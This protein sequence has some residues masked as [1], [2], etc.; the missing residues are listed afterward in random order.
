MKVGI[1]VQDE[2]P[3]LGLV[4]PRRL[5]RSLTRPGHAGVLRAS[6]PRDAP[7][8]EALEEAAVHRFP[9]LRRS[10]AHRWIATASPVNLLWS[11]WIVRVAR[12]EKL[13]ILVSSN[14]RV[15]MSTIVAARWLRVPIIL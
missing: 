5:G 1:V 9:Y 14:L 13:D 15:A 6:G 3:H 11:F 12:R 2:Y 8:Y 7:E 4:R 10:W